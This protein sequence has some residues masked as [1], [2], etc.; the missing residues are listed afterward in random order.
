MRIIHSTDSGGALILLRRFGQCNGGNTSGL[1]AAIHCG[2]GRATP[3]LEHGHPGQPA[4]TA[5]TPR[6]AVN[7]GGTQV[8]LTRTNFLATVTFGG[9]RR[10][11]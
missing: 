6:A 8:T 10:P 11:T 2:S 4:L 7:T 1:M 9:W 5:V 3:D